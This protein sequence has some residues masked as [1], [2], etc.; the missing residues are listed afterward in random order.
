MSTARNYRLKTSQMHQNSMALNQQQLS[1][2]V[3]QQQLSQFHDATNSTRPLL[4]LQPLDAPPSSMKSL[5]I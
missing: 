1:Q 5:G 2:L 3:Q 4:C